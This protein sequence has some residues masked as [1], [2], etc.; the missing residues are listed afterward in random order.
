MVFISY[1][2]ELIRKQCLYFVVCTLLIKINQSTNQWHKVHGL[3][4]FCDPRVPC[5]RRLA[6]LLKVGPGNCKCALRSFFCR[7]SDD[8][9]SWCRRRWTSTI[10]RNISTTLQSCTS[11]DGSTRSTWDGDTFLST[12]FFHQLLLLSFRVNFRPCLLC[13]LCV[14]ED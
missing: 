9:W 4:N 1:C 13:H 2:F 3:S 8:R 14:S 7:F 10:S 5:A 12:C 6:A 11:K